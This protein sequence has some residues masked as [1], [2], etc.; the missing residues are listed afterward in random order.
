M[1][2]IIPFLCSAECT[3]VGVLHTQCAVVLDDNIVVII[4]SVH[5]SD[6]I[7]II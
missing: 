2:Y 6:K 4:A 7:N 1:I 5:R 3:R